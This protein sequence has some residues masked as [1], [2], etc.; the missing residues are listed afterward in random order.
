MEWI[1]T[2]LDGIS[3]TWLRV[4]ALAGSVGVALGIYQMVTGWR[5]NRR[6]K[7]MDRRLD[8]A[9]QERATIRDFLF[10]EFG[11]RAEIRALFEAP[12]PGMTVSVGKRREKK[13]TFLLR[14]QGSIPH[15]PR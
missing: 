14:C 12:E 6:L 7:E 15:I 13:P 2:W 9:E 3:D 5:A 8:K 10:Q 4:F 1:T 11:K